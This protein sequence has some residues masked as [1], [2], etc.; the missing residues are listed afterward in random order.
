MTSPT[1]ST[2]FG[3]EVESNLG[4]LSQGIRIGTCVSPSAQR[5]SGDDSSPIDRTVGFGGVYDDIGG[6]PHVVTLHGGQ[7]V[8]GQGVIAHM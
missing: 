3:E 8:R 6:G 5:C 2:S 7:H 4:S 1:D